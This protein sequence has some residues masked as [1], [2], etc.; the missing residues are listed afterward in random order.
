MKNK[1]ERQMMLNEDK[2]NKQLA[3]Y[4]NQ[5]DQ[6]MTEMN[7]INGYRG[8]EVIEEEEEDEN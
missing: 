2:Y 5:L 6:L 3:V 7:Q 1:Y 4:T 8:V